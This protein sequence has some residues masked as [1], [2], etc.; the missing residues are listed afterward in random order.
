MKILM[1]PSRLVPS[2]IADE[3]VM[4]SP[5]QNRMKKMGIL[6]VVLRFSDD[7]QRF[8]F[9]CCLWNLQQSPDFWA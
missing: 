7:P 6:E 2:V 9:I 3:E 8:S 4:T 5:V 1:V